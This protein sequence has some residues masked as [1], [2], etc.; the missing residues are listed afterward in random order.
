[1]AQMLTCRC[2]EIRRLD[3]EEADSYAHEHLRLIERGRDLTGAEDYQCD[4]TQSSWVLDFPLRHWAEDRRGR[5]RLRKLP[6][7]DDEPP[8]GALD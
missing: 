5:P 7:N 8:V 1:M 6:L 2:A 4:Q 3:G